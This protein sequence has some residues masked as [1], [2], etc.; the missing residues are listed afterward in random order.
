M[1]TFFNTFS[2]IPFQYVCI[3]VLICQHWLGGFKV[4]LNENQIMI[5][6]SLLQNYVH[7]RKDPEVQEMLTRK[8]VTGVWRSIQCRYH[9]NVKT[10]TM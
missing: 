5:S 9:F 10:V 1:D 7:Q 8:H 4:N 6:K 2:E 3:S